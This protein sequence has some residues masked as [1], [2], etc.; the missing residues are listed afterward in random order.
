MIRNTTRH[1]PEPHASFEKIAR[2][3]LW[4]DSLETRHDIALDDHIVSVVSIREA[5]QRVYD[6]GRRH[7]EVDHAENRRITRGKGSYW[8]V[9]R[10]LGHL[11][12]LFGDGSETRRPT[13]A[14]D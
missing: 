2:D 12:V 11:R 5:F 8:H 6:L 14:N 4:I 13:S 3:I 1:S 9:E 7:A 10:V